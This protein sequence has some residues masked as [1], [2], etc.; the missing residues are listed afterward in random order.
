MKKLG[1]TLTYF[2]YDGAGQLAVEEGDAGLSVSGRQY[3]TR[4]HLGTACGQFQVR[5]LEP[6]NLQ[7][8][9]QLNSVE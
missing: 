2:I 7:N 4:D 6:F 1:T 8:W 5:N 3:L 9:M